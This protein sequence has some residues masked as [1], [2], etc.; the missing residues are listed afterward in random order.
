M[1]YMA[2]FNRSLFSLHTEGLYVS[3]PLICTVNV[4]FPHTNIEQEYSS[5]L[6]EAR[7]Y[8]RDKSK[9]CIDNQDLKKECCCCNLKKECCCC[10]PILFFFLT[11]EISESCAE[12]WDERGGRKELAQNTIYDMSFNRIYSMFFPFYFS[13]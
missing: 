8:P 7:H 1:G 11:L 9:V 5:A 3:D 12:M 10:L 6:L 2:H 4:I 13:F